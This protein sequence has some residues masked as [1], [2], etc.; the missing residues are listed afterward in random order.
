MPRI[1]FI[2]TSIFDLGCLGSSGIAVAADAP[3]RVRTNIVIGPNDRVP[4][5]CSAIL[6]SF[7][8]RRSRP[9]ILTAKLNF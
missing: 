8:L 5:N 3:S 7:F 6:T 9:W 1:R 2:V 4:S